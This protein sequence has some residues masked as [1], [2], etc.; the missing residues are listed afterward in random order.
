M[1]TE[2]MASFEVEQ[3]IMIGVL[4]T[5]STGKSTF[6]AR[7]AHELRRQHIQVA[8]VADLGEQAQRMGLPILYNHT[9]SS[10]LWIITRGVSNELEAWL[11]ADVVLVDRPAP[12]ALGY[13][14]AALDYRHE[15]PDPTE[16]T[17]LEALVRG[18]SARYN[19]LFR[20]TLDPSIPLG[21][22]KT[23]DNDSQFR[24]LADH[25]VGRVLRDLNLAHEL[26]PAEG[27]DPALDRAMSF[28]TTSLA[29]QPVG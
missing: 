18:H 11:H 7:L 23:R 6:I 13:Y 9:W 2:G 4:G 17:Y 24:L 25:Y 20:T 22:T 1:T 27:H 15:Q 5:H 28:I 8:T 16:L 19:L 21:D 26:L 3:P 29:G 12:D 14:R 10:T